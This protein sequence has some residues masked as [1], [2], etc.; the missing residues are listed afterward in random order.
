[1]VVKSPRPAKQ[2]QVLV[3]LGTDSKQLSPKFQFGCQRQLRL[4]R[5]QGQPIAAVVL[6]L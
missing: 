6:E 1:M 5:D 4:S 2:S 3:Q